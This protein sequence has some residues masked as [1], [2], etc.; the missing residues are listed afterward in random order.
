MSRP[1]LGLQLYTIGEEAEKDFLGTLKRVA[2][3][4]YEGVEFAGYFETP[5]RKLAKAVNDLGLKTAG[6][7]IAMDVLDSSRL[8]DELDYADRIDCES[9]ICP[10]LPEKYTTAEDEFKTAAEKFNTIGERC[11]EAGMPFL[12]HVHGNEFVDFNGRSGMDILL[13]ECDSDLVN[14]ELDTY[15]VEHAGIDA[16]SFY[17]ASPGRYPYI[18]FKDM[19]DRE[20]MRDTEVGEGVVATREI[21]EAT[22][23][24]SVRWFVVEQEAFDI[25]PM[26][27]VRVSLLNLRQMVEE[28]LR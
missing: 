14:F 2:E 9:I 11:R 8:S 4:G 20:E 26:E 21:I 24:H 18:H 1:E 13:K 27:S 17:R 12:Y 23:P 15:W 16:L 5:A 3:I 19:K 7:H 10:I 6:T 22:R 25:P 28:L